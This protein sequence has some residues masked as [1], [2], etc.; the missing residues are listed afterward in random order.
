MRRYDIVLQEIRPSPAALRSSG[1][2]CRKRGQGTDIMG[3]W[4]RLVLYHAWCHTI[5]Y[6]ARLTYLVARAHHI[7]LCTKNDAQGRIYFE[8]LS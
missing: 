2:E 5:P 8:Q 6:H 4:L 3:R 1:G 7:V